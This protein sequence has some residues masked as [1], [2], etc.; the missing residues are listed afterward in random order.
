M[1]LKMS[2]SES[3]NLKF[4]YNFHFLQFSVVCVLMIASP[5]KKNHVVYRWSDVRGYDGSNTRNLVDCYRLHPSHFFVALRNVYF[6]CKLLISELKFVQNF[7]VPSWIFHH[8]N[9][10]FGPFWPM[11]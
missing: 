10:S 7:W 2:R 6:N 1:V 5:I 4:F 9:C 3:A 11:I 8:L